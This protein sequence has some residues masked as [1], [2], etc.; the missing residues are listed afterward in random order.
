MRDRPWAYAPAAMRDEE[1]A[2]YL[3][4]SAS[5][6][7]E[8]VCQGRIARHRIDGLTLYRRDDLDAF[9]D[10]ATGRAAPSLPQREASWP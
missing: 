3:G 7:R 5:K 9:L 8:W 10:H 2:R 6:L 1:A 4:V